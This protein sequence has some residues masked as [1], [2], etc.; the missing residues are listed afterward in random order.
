MSRKSPHPPPSKSAQPLFLTDEDRVSVGASAKL[1]GNVEMFLSSPLDRGGQL[2]L[3]PVY[4][5]H[6]LQRRLGELQ[7]RSHRPYRESNPRFL[8]RA[9]RSPV[10]VPTKLSQLLRLYTYEKLSLHLHIGLYLF[11][12][13]FIFCGSTTLV[14]PV[15]PS[16]KVSRSHAGIPH[17]VGIL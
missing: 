13:F 2:T 3:L 14:E 5:R 1:I 6:S 16:V 10:T 15:L 17:S 9:A 4:P 11:F 7:K 8:A 12:Y